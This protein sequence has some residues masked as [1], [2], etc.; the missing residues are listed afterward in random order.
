MKDYIKYIRNL[1]GNH[2]IIMNAAACIITNENNEVLLQ[3]RSDDHLW[4]LP[5]GIMEL[6]ETE[7]E[8]CIREVKEETGLEIEITSFLG[9]FHNK[10]KHWPNGDK[11]HVICAVFTADV[12]GGKLN[13]DNEETLDLAYFSVDNLPN[14]E[15]PDH[16]EAI[17]Y[18]YT[19]NRGD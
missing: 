6:G 10:H 9:T 11:A 15:A 14:I 5:G 3:H 18:Y 12:I 17:H 13:K 16:I 8:T 7:K 1:V 19:T 2:K 4:G